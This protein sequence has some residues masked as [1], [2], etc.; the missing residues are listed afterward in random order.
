MN[1]QPNTPLDDVRMRASEVFNSLPDDDRKKAGLGYSLAQL[2]T[3]AQQRQANRDMI[4]R[5][6]RRLADWCK[7]IERHIESE[8]LS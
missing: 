1:S 4:A 8:Y 2:T 6:D 5:E 7:N 3:I